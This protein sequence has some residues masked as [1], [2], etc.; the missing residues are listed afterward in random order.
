MASRF[1]LSSLKQTFSHCYVCVCVGGGGLEGD[2]GGR[3]SLIEGDQGGGVTYRGC[4]GGRSLIEGDQG[5]G[6]TYGG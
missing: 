3:G 4:S 1:D 2:Q 6:G 5:G